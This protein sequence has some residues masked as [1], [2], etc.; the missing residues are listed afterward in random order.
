M[1]GERLIQLSRATDSAIELLR[2]A[3][4]PEDVGRAVLQRVAEAVSCHWAAYWAVDPQSRAARS[5]ACW[6][7]LGPEGQEFEQTARLRSLPLNLG[8]IAKV[9]RTGKPV[10]TDTLVLDMGLPRSLQ[11][12]RA[13][14]RSGLWF[15]VKTDTAAYGVIELL[16]RTLPTISPETLVAVERAGCR[17]GYVLEELRSDGQSSRLH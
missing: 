13:G 10:W 9:W 3:S 11:A 8:N 16:A 15:A 7:G 17:L 1:I 5:A 2:G 4:R 14:L 12:S 6:N